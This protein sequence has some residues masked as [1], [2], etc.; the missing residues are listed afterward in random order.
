MELL[1]FCVVKNFIYVAFLKESEAKESGAHKCQWNEQI[2]PVFFFESVIIEV[3]HIINV[4][5]GQNT[6]RDVPR[7]FLK[8]YFSLTIIQ[9][10]HFL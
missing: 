6:E 8:E 10:E 4:P 1:R 9:S 2:L 5:Q 3:A 7:V